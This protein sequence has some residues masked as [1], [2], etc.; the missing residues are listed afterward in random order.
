MKTYIITRFSIYDKRQE[1][2][3]R[4]NKKDLFNIERLNY[5]FNVFLKKT[6]HSIIY[7]TYKN[8]ITF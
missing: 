5:K 2:N 7:Q 4:L 8:L 6:V 3:T 1:T